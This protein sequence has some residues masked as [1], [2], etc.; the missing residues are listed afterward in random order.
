MK[1]KY[2]TKCGDKLIKVKDIY[3]IKEYSPETGKIIEKYKCPNY[4]RYLGDMEGVDYI[5]FP[6]TIRMK[7][8]PKYDYNHDNNIKNI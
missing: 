3:G 6:G 4:G 8:V 1:H 2:C 5:G 7:T